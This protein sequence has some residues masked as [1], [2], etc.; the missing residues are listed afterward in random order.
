MMTPKDCFNHGDSFNL[1][2]TVSKYVM[3]LLPISNC[4]IK[5]Y[6]L[7]V[8][9]TQ[10]HIFLQNLSMPVIALLVLPSVE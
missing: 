4:Q 5:F 10:L 3:Q 8:H 9:Q 2:Y 6:S 7:V 1:F